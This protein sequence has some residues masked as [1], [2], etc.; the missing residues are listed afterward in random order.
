MVNNLL[1]PARDMQRFFANHDGKSA[2]MRQLTENFLR[3]VTGE[4]SLQQAD[5]KIDGAQAETDKDVPP[6]RYARFVDGANA[7]FR[8]RAKADPAKFGDSS[9]HDTAF[10][11]RLAELCQ[12]D[13]SRQEE[14]YYAN[15][16]EGRF[17]QIMGTRANC[18]DPAWPRLHPDVE[19]AIE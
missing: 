19:K 5:G 6:G 16:F 7:Y 11:Q 3:G 18:P 4:P 2:A 9:S 10:C 15:D 13:M 1:A 12:S 8:E 14:Y 17:A